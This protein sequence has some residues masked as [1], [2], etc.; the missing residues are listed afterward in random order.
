M[1]PVDLD[2]IREICFL[3]ST[4]PPSN[5]CDRKY[6]TRQMQTA[7]RKTGSAQIVKCAVQLHSQFQIRV[8]QRETDIC[9][10]SSDIDGSAYGGAS[11]EVMS[12]G[13]QLLNSEGFPTQSRAVMS[14]D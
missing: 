14:P 6:D 3:V 11:Y 9:I 7:V 4:S 10:S 2:L 12:A 5:L 8:S 13:K 1:K